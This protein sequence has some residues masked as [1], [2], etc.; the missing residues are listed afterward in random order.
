MRRTVK[1]LILVSVALGVVL[2]GFV[3]GRSCSHHGVK[4]VEQIAALLDRSSMP[5][6]RRAELKEKLRLVHPDAEAKKAKRRFHKETIAILEAEEFDA[7][8]YR[9]RLDEMLADRN[10]RRQRMAEV[11]VEIASELNQEERKALADIFRRK[12]RFK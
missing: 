3:G 11:M 4:R 7:E 9:A 5:E 6:A 1:L 12:S 10:R 8:A 2:A